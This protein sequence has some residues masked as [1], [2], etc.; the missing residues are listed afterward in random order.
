MNDSFNNQGFSSMNFSLNQPYLNQGKKPEAAARICF[1]VLENF[2]MVS[3]TSAI[4]VLVTA[5][6][7]LSQAR[8]SYSTVGIERKN[9]VSDIGVDVLCDKQLSDIC[10]VDDQFDAYVVC[11]GY[12]CD[13][14]EITEL[15]R[16]LNR[17][18][19]SRKAYVGIWNGGIH[20]AYAKVAEHKVLSVHPDNHAFCKS[21]LFNTKISNQ[22]IVI[23][24]NLYTCSSSHGTTQLFLSF[25]SS[26][27]GQDVY[28]AVNEILLCDAMH[29]SFNGEEYNTGAVLHMEGYPIELVRVLELMSSNIDE[30]LTI[31]DIIQYT[32]VSRRQL[33]RFFK[34]HIGVSPSRYYLELRISHARCL[35]KQTR[36]NITEV[37][38]SSGFISS[39]HFS[40]CFKEY[41]GLSPRAFRQQAAGS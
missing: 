32:H 9:V 34:H 11:G 12:R 3:F 36:K 31:E 14:N 17:S 18:R 10:P 38:L 29:S 27:L 20:L 30:P 21:E 22:P 37:A 23:D 13:V 2:S 24:E 5:N 19:S 8:F 40:N 4:D 7:T 26:T 16:F 33:E 28:R 39:S 6:L 25:V 35:L 41:Y 1:I 15:T